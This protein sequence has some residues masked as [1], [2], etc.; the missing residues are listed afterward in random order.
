MR[1]TCTRAALARGYWLV[2]AL[3]LVVIADLRPFQFVL[4]GPSIPFFR[5]TFGPAADGIMTMAT[6]SPHQAK[7][8]RAKPFYE[9]YKKRFNDE[10]DYTTSAI[11]YISCEIVEQALATAGLDKEKL[12]ATYASKT[13]DTI[14]GPISFKGPRSNLP[15]LISQIQN[16]EIHLLWPPEYATT[17]YQPKPDWPKK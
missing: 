6:W 4:I 17:T 7:W 2:T 15:P 11:V 8:P 9:A 10:P 13:F 5:K 3:Y 16:G 1:W 12:R 14:S